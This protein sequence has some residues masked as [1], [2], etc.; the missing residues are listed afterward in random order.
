MR[1]PERA[2]YLHR[3]RARHAL[4]LS[5]L[6]L[7]LSLAAIESLAQDAGKRQVQGGGQAA[8]TPQPVAGSGTAGPAAPSVEK[9]GGPASN[10][11]GVGAKS[12]VKGAG[13][14]SDG[15]TPGDKK[16]N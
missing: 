2:E 11:K 13:S 4:Q 8:G 16:P 1:D 6:L 7:C 14:K 9:P 15:K 3:P 12:D 5:A 10:G